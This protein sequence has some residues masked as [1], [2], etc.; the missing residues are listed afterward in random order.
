VLTLIQNSG[1]RPDAAARFRVRTGIVTV[2]HS[3]QPG[4]SSLRPG[5]VHGPRARTLMQPPTVSVVQHGIHSAVSFSTCMRTPAVHQ[6]AQCR[7]A[8]PAL[9]RICRP[10][11]YRVCSTPPPIHTNEGSPGLGPHEAFCLGRRQHCQQRADLLAVE[12]ITCSERDWEIGRLGEPTANSPVR[13]AGR[14]CCPSYR[15]EARGSGGHRG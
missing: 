11:L 6:Q 7:C 8:C 12:Q 2:R 5:G 3:Q 15:G 9:C 14:A 13:S 1:N 10:C 4:A